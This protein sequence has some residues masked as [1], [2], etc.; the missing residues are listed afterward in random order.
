MPS[1]GTAFFYGESG[2][3]YQ[4]DIYSSDTN[5][6]NI[7]AIYIFCKISVDKDLN[8]MIVPLYIGETGELGKRIDNHE[9]WECVIF[10]GC[11]HIC[12]KTI[13]GRKARLEMEKDLRHNYST[14]CNDQ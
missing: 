11:T 1:E 2:N 13:S 10:E 12:V 8:L 6:R 9:K 4:F 14:P 5:F 3:E 7:G